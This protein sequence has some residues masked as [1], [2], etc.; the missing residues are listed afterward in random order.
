M[1]LA[2][3]ET[4]HGQLWRQ[5]QAFLE[6]HEYFVLPTTQLPPFEIDMPYP[7]RSRA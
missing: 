6:K 4:A 3:A 2:R 1:D 5:F 7:L